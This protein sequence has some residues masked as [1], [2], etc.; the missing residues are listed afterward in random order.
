LQ[1][2]INAFG[3][4]EWYR[5]IA[6]CFADANV[7]DGISASPKVNAHRA[8]PAR[9][10]WVAVNRTVDVIAYHRRKQRAPN[11]ENGCKDEDN[12]GENAPA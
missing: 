2:K 3:G 5:H 10:Q 1:S 4:E 9:V 7:F 6:R 8:N 11:A 12:D